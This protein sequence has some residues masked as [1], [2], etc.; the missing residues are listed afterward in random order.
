[1][2]TNEDIIYKWQLSS[3]ILQA[4]AWIRSRL[5]QMLERILN[6]PLEDMTD[7]HPK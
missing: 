7:A 2:I 3:Y 5:L 1:M 4:F 6:A